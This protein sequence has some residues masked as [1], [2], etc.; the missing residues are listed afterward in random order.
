MS[1]QNFGSDI[2]QDVAQRG[3]RLKKLGSDAII[4]SQ[5]HYKLRTINRMSKGKKKG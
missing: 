4:R 3:R 2:A 5:P 1:P